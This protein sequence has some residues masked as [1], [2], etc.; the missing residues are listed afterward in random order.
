MAAVF[1]HEIGSPLSAMSTHLQLMAE[2]PNIS[3][4]TQ[5][6]LTLIQDQISRIT[7]IVEEL[8]S[9]TR[10]A[11][12]ARTSVQLNQILQQLLLFLEQHLEKLQ[13]KVETRF[14]PDLPPIEANPQQLQQVF[15]NLLN[16]ACDAMPDGG[17]VAME[18]TTQVEH[19]GTT[20]AV[21]SI[22][23]NGTGIPEEK[24]AHIF[25]PFFT[26]KDLHR[27]TGLGLSIAAKIIRQ[28]QGTIELHSV[29]G[30]GSKFTLRFPARVPAPVVQQ[31]ALTGKGNP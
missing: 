16:N 8:L 14:S 3:K 13:V 10:A 12:Q 11:V 28:H 24:Q 26:T 22:E 1:A 15:L 18:T 25:E 5:R 7:G 2:D 29:P 6:R 21:I 19:D 9:E 20:Y 27:G 17:A 4:G 30:A 23:D 31:E